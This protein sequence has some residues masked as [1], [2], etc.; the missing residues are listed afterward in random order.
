MGRRSFE[1]DKVA[2]GGVD[3]FLEHGL[4]SFEILRQDVSEAVLE[5]SEDVSDLEGA[6]AD[7]VV[8]VLGAHEGE[9]GVVLPLLLRQAARHED[10]L[11]GPV[12][13]QRVV[14]HEPE[15]V[16]G[17]GVVLPSGEHFA[18]V[19]QQHAE[20]EEAPHPSRVGLAQVANLHRAFEHEGEVPKLGEAVDHASHLRELVQSVLLIH[21]DVEGNMAVGLY[22]LYQRDLRLSDVFDLAIG[23][24]PPEQLGVNG[25]VHFAIVVRLDQ[26]SDVDVSVGQIKARGKRAKRFNLALP[27]RRNNELGKPK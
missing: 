7:V 17:K 12:V 3:E 9:V 24:G 5:D 19:D 2:L 8:G 23:V 25:L 16:L 27:H 26:N 1:V 13:A 10:P 18:Q 14:L 15:D 21:G 22:H 4:S 11:L 6:F 20:E